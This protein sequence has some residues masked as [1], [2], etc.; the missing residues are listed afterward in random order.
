[1][2]ANV[3]VGLSLAGARCGSG[4]VERAALSDPS[5]SVRAA[6]ARAVAATSRGPE[7]AAALA[8]CAS[9]ERSVE[10]APLCASARPPT[11]PGR[12]HDVLVYVEGPPHAEPGARIPYV[13]ELGDGLL[14][15]GTADRRGALFEAEAPPGMMRLRDVTAPEPQITGSR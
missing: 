7:D 12:P 5:P 8:R 9:H 15:A 10:V 14:R 4:D 13:L 2:R 3:L 1:V 11:K 6:A